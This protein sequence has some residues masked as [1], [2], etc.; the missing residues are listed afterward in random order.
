MP[1][2]DQNA[3][4]MPMVLRFILIFQFLYSLQM[5]QKSCPKKGS[6]IFPPKKFQSYSLYQE[7]TQDALICFCRMDDLLMAIILKVTV[8]YWMH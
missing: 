6:T 1:F 4:K 8:N 2:V 3:A 5:K 7:A